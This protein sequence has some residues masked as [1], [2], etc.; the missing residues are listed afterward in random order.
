MRISVLAF[1]AAA[2]LSAADV[3]DFSKTVPLDA[4]GH[5]SLDTFKGSIHIT[6]WDRP[7]AEIRARIQADTG[8]DAVPADD[9]EIR[10]DAMSSDVRV[11][12]DYHHQNGTL[13]LVYYTIQIPRGASLRVKD[14]KSESDISGI[15]G[16]IE[17]NTYK[18][19]ARLDGIQ[20]AFDGETY[21]GDIRAIFARFSGPGR[22]ETYKGSI[23]MSLPRSS[24]FELHAELERRAEFDCDFPRTI[25]TSRRQSHMEGAVNGGG[26]SLRVESYRG[27]IRLRSI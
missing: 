13:P 18:G 17:F 26:P 6:A 19:T 16:D 10:A 4:K 23:D 27:K 12:T 22:V 24:A 3:K 9:V 20:G 1:L 21:K 14:Y 25:H 8:W 7:Q 5:F 2:L 11:K 15:Q